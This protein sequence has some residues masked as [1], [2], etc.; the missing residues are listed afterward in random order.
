MTKI[1]VKNSVTGETFHWENTEKEVHSSLESEY[2][3]AVQIE[4]WGKDDPVEKDRRLLRFY[5]NNLI[6]KIIEEEEL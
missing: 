1:V 5:G 4:I 2:G 6:I 3:S